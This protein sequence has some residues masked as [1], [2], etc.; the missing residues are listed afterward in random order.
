VVRSSAPI[1][2]ARA[3]EAEVMGAARL[4][5][6]TGLEAAQG[7]DNLEVVGI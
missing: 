3:V 2:C 1:G 4:A 7:R 6:G 5:A